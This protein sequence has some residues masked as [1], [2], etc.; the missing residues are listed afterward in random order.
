MGGRSAAA[1]VAE[2]LTQASSRSHGGCP[3]LGSRRPAEA[4]EYVAEPR[5]VAERVELRAERR[6]VR[7]ILRTGD[8]PHICLPA[9]R[10]APALQAWPPSASASDRRRVL[11][12]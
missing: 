8:V 5:A 2:C 7:P 1:A 6:A 3:A 9:A 12:T 4:A 10:I 11:I